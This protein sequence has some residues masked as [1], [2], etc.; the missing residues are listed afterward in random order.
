[1]KTLKKNPDFACRRVA[2]E[3]ILLPIKKKT[4]D[5]EALYTLNE[6]GGFL[7]DN[8]EKAVTR[9]KLALAVLDAYEA[10]RATV[11]KDVEAFLD[12]MVK[13]GAVVEA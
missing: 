12:R 10:E 3:T 11:V 9:E 1:M 6:L 5:F 4:A 13:I 7:W 2:G 8:L